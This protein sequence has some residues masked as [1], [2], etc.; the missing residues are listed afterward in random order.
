MKPNK[1]FV[2]AITVALVGAIT[3]ISPPEA[4][5]H[6]DTLSGP[7]VSAARKALETGNVN[8]ILV[9]VQPDDDA[10]IR[11][12]FGEALAERQHAGSASEAAETRFF[13]TVVKIHRAGEGAPFEGIKPAN[14]DIGPAVPAAD[15]ALESGNPEP[16]RELLTK[17]VQDGLEKHFHEAREQRAHD[18][19]DVAAG[20]AFVKSYVEYTHFVEGV[21]QAATAAGHHEHGSEGI[22][23]ASGDTAHAEHSAHAA[24][25]A[26]AKPAE[27]HGEHGNHSG[28]LPWALAGALGLI[29]VGQGGWMM[30]R[31]KRKDSQSR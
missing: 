18:V 17:A 28:H 5:A 31:S 29:A 6:C 2:T 12:A 3:A 15:R 19:D 24:Q 11:K 10:T 13:E 7:V 16:V 23:H 27:G 1:Y 14:T 25:G 30:S 4:Q 20:R 26:D 22:R 9:W 8:L 21:Y